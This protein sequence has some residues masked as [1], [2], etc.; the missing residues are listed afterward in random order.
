MP[1]KWNTHDDLTAFYVCKF[2][3]DGIASSKREVADRLGIPAGSFN[4][5]VGNFKALL[6]LG[7]LDNYAQQSAAVYNAN[8]DKSEADLRESVLRGFAS[9]PR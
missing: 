9:R 3:P 2:G 8:K 1:H 4:M 6:G 5:R 7:G